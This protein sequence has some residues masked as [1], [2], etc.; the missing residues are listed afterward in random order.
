[1]VSH[2]DSYAASG[3]LW[4]SHF[5]ADDKA[6]VEAR[7]ASLI[8]DDMDTYQW[9]EADCLFCS[10]GVFPDDSKFG[11]QCKHCTGF[12]CHRHM[13]DCCEHCRE[14]YKSVR[15]AH[16]NEDDSEAI[17]NQQAA[18]SVTV[19][20]QESLP[21]VLLAQGVSLY[22]CMSRRHWLVDPRGPLSHPR[23]PGARL[24]RVARPHQV[25]RRRSSM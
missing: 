2:S 9:G 7:Q 16:E 14:E 18:E 11:G 5:I 23:H 17:P 24:A 22:H 19:P 25:R 6:D 10:C 12:V 20:P 8:M 4:P 21:V 1:M 13:W 15:L 3:S